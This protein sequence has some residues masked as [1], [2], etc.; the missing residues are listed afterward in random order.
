ME[1]RT[2]L[3]PEFARK[4]IDAGFQLTVEE[5]NQ[6]AIP[7]HQYQQ[8]GCRTVPAHSWKSDAPIDAIILGL[9]ELE[10]GAE[11]LRHRHIHFAHVYKNQAG[12]EKVLKRF[13]DGDG[14]L[15]DLE[16]LVDE[17]G[18]RVAAFGHWAG[19][20]GA[21]LAMLGWA[22]QMS[23]G[24][25]VL[26]SVTS[27]PNRDVLLNEVKAEIAKTGRKPTA[28]VIGALGRS[29]RGAVELCRSA[30][31]E[32]VQWD[33]E[34]TKKGGPF[35]EVLEVDVL[36]N[37][38]FVQSSIPPFVTREMLITET[39]RLSMICDVSCDP[40]GDY[41]PLPIYN[42]CTSFDKPTLRLIDGANPL[43]LIAIDHL[44]S[45]LPVESSHDFCS[46]LMPHLLTLD[47]LEQ[48]VWKRAHDLFKQK[49]ELVKQEI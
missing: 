43:D 42:R 10:P 47:N 29:G 17:D 45:L 33:F 31:V 34:E 21:A 49:T 37:C 5:S 19:F 41:N 32:L 15:Y 1:Q 4:L 23:G 14:V 40:Y 12:W 20:A 27:R 7:I 8:Q 13:T 2:A 16:F 3:T 44:P 30:G 39:R 35:A 18:R 28:M 25:P 22:R 6:S 38:V 46:Q 26:P 48:G 9:K 36:L 24:Q 11:P